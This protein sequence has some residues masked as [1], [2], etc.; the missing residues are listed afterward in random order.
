MKTRLILITIFSVCAFALG[1]KAQDLAG[2]KIYINPGHGGYDAETGT[3]VAGEFANGWRSDGTDATDRWV[4]TIPYPSATSEGFWESKIALWRGLELRRLLEGAGA[5]VMMSRTQNRSEDDRILTQIGR[6]A[7]NWGADMFLSI[8]SNANGKNYLLNIYRGADPKTAEEAENF[9]KSQEAVAGSK[10]MATIGW[11][12]LHDNPL[13]CW[14]ARKS[15]DNPLVVSDS[16]FY[17]TYHLGVLRRLWVPG[18]LTET[19]FHDYRPETHRMLNPDYSNVVAYQLFTSICEYFDADQPATGIIAGE[20]KDPAT[21]FTHTYYYGG[22]EGDHDRY[23][24]LNGALVT[25]TG[26][27]VNLSY[28]TD[29]F[30]NGLFYFP[31]LESGT[32][33]VKI[34]ANGFATYEADVECEAGKVRGPIALLEQTGAHPNIFA[35]RLGVKDSRTVSFALNARARSVR[36][37][38][39]KEGET[40][41]S[42]DLGSFE[43]GHNT[44]KIPDDESVAEGEYEWS[45]TVEGDG[46]PASPMKFAG[47]D[48]GTLAISSPRG[49]TID[50]DP[51]SDSFGNIYATSVANDSKTWGRC[52]A[53]VYVVDALHND[54]FG[55]GDTP[56]SGGVDW[57]GTYSPM[58]A[59]T[60]PDGKVYICDWSNAHSGVWIMDPENPS[61]DFRQLFASGSRD[62]SGLVTIDG[63]NVHGSVVDVCFKGEGEEMAMYT[64]DE[65]LPTKFIHRYDLGGNSSEQWSGAPSKDYAQKYLDSELL[66][67]SQSLAADGRGGI[68][69][70]QNRYTNSVAC[71]SL[72]HINGD[73]DEWDYAC[74]DKEVIPSSSWMGAVAASA[75]G[76]LV[77]VAGLDKIYIC[78]AEFDS[79]N[80]PSLSLKYTV[81]SPG[82]SRPYG[83]ALDA[84]DNLYAVYDDTE[85]AGGGIAAYALPREEDVFTTPGSGTLS[86]HGPVSGVDSMETPAIERN[87]NIFT[88]GGMQIEVYSLSGAKVAG[89]YRIDITGL[90]RGVYILRA[91]RQTIKIS[92]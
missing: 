18:Y 76:G 42:F 53:G 66:N 15:A 9:D 56:Y 86:F 88:A 38:L 51:R 1:V 13:T 41:K 65:D 77:A 23:L 63:V 59:K 43:R 10:R 39:L 47:N 50:R 6:E 33:H 60:A 75:D 40:V 87:G 79:G 32:Y 44:A 46:A 31:D 27:G 90:D 28:T 71:P 85:T 52:G 64:A 74:G 17:G 54:V 11:Q 26:N 69:V 81:S 92:L 45:L 7:T 24:P 62:S 55:Q 48:T 3:K 35:S 25:L 68:W 22:E 14:Q 5:T 82:S 19:A 61:D 91:G 78:A 37:N 8:H 36:L 72:M 4:P 21:I 29:D 2:K 49:L 16:T 80:T 57:S 89:G 20:A 73:T 58:R 83:L 12:H 30:Y 70:G 67:G 84:A 34:V